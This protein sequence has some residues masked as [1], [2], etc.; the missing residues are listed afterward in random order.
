MIAN[1]KKPVSTSLRAALPLIHKSCWRRLDER[2][3]STTV[4]TVR[5]SKRT[6]KREFSGAGFS[7]EATI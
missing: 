7:A 1:A 3:C 2:P 4:K 6:V 5:R